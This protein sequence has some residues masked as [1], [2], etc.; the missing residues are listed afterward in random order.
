[1]CTHTCTPD[2]RMP[3]SCTR[4]VFP[5]S[6]LPLVKH[7]AQRG[8]P[9]VAPICLGRRCGPSPFWEPSGRLA[10]ASPKSCFA[11]SQPPA[12]STSTKHKKGN[13]NTNMEKN[14][15]THQEQTTPTTV[16]Q[17]PNNPLELWSGKAGGICTID[18]DATC[19]CVLPH[20]GRDGPLGPWKTYCI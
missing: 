6:R 10:A 16:P 4:A 17:T 11:C 18:F 7:H 8:R 15:H 20:L 5:G 13:H 2:L 1:M 19:F 14:T 3:C 12:A 9:P